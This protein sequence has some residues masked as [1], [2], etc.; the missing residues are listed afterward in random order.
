MMTFHSRITHRSFI[1]EILL[2]SLAPAVSQA[3]TGLSLV[4]LVIS[5]DLSSRHPALLSLVPS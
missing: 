2:I 4:G 1:R 3:G 5:Q